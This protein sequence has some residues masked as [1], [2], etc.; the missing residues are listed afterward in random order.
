MRSPTTTLYVR[1]RVPGARDRLGNEEPAWSEPRAVP[2]CLL[3]PADA[4]D[5]GGDR[6]EGARA[7]ARAHFPKGF[8]GDLR[9]ALVSPGGGTW[10]RVVGEPSAYPDG[11]VRGPWNMH[12]LLGRTDG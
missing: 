7:A 11:A 9:G 4:A 1:E 3:A 10:L 12:V 8:S 5:L 2:G 6:P